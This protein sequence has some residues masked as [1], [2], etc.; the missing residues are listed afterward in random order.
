MRVA[1]SRLR[2]SAGRNLTSRASLAPRASTNGPPGL[3]QGFTIPRTPSDHRVRPLTLA[4]ALFGYAHAALSA[5][6]QALT[7]SH[8]GA[9]SLGYTGLLASDARGRAL[10]SCLELRASQL[11]LNVDTRGPRHPLRIDPL[12]R[13]EGK[14][15]DAGGFGAHL[16][17][18][19][20]GNTAPIGAL[21]ITSGAAAASVCTRSGQDRIGR[22]PNSRATPAAGLKRSRL[23]EGEPC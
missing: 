14:L 13:Q 15:I 22:A 2:A 3:E 20:D 1:L 5:R 16:A 4:L 7:L 23:G 9:P 8:A 11:L 21:G 12:I 18:A 17:S 10:R 19:S 6:A